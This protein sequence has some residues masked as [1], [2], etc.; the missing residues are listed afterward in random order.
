[1]TG[2]PEA[3]N[4]GRTRDEW[5]Q[6]LRRHKSNLSLYEGFN[7]VCWPWMMLNTRRVALLSI[8]P[9]KES[10][11]AEMYVLSDKR[12]GPVAV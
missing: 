9:G 12:G 8:N 2:S 5:D 10:D 3:L 7:P 11:K 1:M 4:A 6:E